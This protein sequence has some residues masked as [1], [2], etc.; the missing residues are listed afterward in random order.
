MAALGVHMEGDNDVSLYNDFSQWLGKP[1]KYRVLFVDRSAWTGVQYPYFIDATTAWVNA[2]A[3]NVDVWTVPVVLDGE[4]FAGVAAGNRDAEFTMLAQA[5]LSTGKPGQ[6]NIRLGWEFNGDWYAWSAL[7]NPSGYKAA[8]R[9]IVS[10]IR[11]VSPAIRIEWCAAFQSWSTFDVSSAY[12]GDDVVDVISM[13]VYDD[14]NSGWDD[15]L[16]GPNGFGLKALRAFAAAHG[17]PEAYAE[18][19]CSTNVDANGGGDSPTF[20]A[21]MKDWIEQGGASVL[22]HAYWNTDL[23]GPDAAIFGALA[24]KVPNAAAEYKRLF[25]K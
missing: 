12:P 13:D 5:A 17:K 6:I 14:W 10:V 18:W 15:I 9:R 16:N 8:F 2:D 25:S 4:T 19:G 21:N 22:Y 7:S 3:G 23:G 11:A 1:V 24:G 20:I